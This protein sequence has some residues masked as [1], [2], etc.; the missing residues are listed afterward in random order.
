[1]AVIPQRDLITERY[2]EIDWMRFRPRPLPVAV[3]E[4][5]TESTRP[6]VP[7][8][9]TPVVRRIDLSDLQ[10]QAEPRDAGFT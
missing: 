8:A 10:L 1:S 7:P 2:D 6:A 9:E 5:S 4:Q 3:P